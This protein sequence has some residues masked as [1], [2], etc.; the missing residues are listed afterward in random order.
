MQGKNACLPKSWAKEEVTPATGD[1]NY[2]IILVIM[3][4][5]II[6]KHYI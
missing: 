3:W 5:L 2:N 6:M 1:I 4:I